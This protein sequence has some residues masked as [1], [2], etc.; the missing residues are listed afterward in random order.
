MDNADMQSVAAGKNAVFEALKS[1]APV[2]CVYIASG[3][4]EAMASKLAWMCK[5]KNV[6]LKSVDRRK[7]EQIGGAKAQGVAAVLADTAYSSVEDILEIAGIRGEPP[8]IIIADGIE[9]PHNL[10]SII[11]SA[12]IFGAHGVIIPSRSAVGLTAVVS[13]AS[14]GAVFHTPVARVANLNSTIKQL[15]KEGLW[16]YGADAG[17][18]TDIHTAD[19]SGACALVVGAE[20]S[21]L[22]RLVRENC[23]AVVSI[24]M[25]GDIS[26]LNASV[27]AGIMMFCIAS[28][29]Q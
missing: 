14:A 21:G 27:A 15:K 9:D 3:L 5:S 12:N 17:G 2:T 19:F 20:G 28:K 24:P 25:Q 10:G 6:P 13:K 18:D 23:D 26:S 16:V 7:V 22:S 8:F 11:R 29:R 4:D 1:N